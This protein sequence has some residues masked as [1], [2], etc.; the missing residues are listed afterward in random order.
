M[1]IQLFA[2]QEMNISHPHGKIMRCGSGLGTNSVVGFA[3]ATA[4]IGDAVN[5]NPSTTPKDDWQ[6]QHNRVVL[7]NGRYTGASSPFYFPS[8]AARNS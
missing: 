5:V 4:Q 2:R 8:T 6:R 1:L 3:S 7:T